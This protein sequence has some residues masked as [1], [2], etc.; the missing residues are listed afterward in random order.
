MNGKNKRYPVPSHR[1]RTVEDAFSSLKWLLLY[2]VEKRAVGILLTC[3]H[4]RHARSTTPC[5]Q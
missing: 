3:R 4:T 5:P 1:L 2:K